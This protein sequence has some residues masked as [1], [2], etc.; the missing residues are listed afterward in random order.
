MQKNKGLNGDL[1]QLPLL[2][3]IMFLKFLDGL[4]KMQE[5]VV[6]PDSI[7]RLGLFAY[8]RSL[9]SHDGKGRHE[10]IAN[11][12]RGVTNRM[13]SG[14]LLREVIDKVN[15]INFTSSEEI[16]LLSLFYESMLKEIWDA[17]GDLGDFCTPR[18]LVRFMV[19]TIAPKL[20]STSLGLPGQS[21]CGQY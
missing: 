15:L 9:E 3:W 18:P 21:G 6:R 7:R 14:Y 8:L 17:A 13:E 10:I 19:E 5:E 20:G 11:I 2:I 1:D 4:E 12:F 16:H